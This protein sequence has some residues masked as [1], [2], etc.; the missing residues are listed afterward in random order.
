MSCEWPREATSTTS[1]TFTGAAVITAVVIV[2]V[3]VGDSRLMEPRGAHALW[4]ASILN[5]SFARSL[6][7]WH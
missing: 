7:T 2:V 4:M 5:L 1:T 3:V 6:E